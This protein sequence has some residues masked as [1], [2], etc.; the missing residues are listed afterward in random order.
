MTFTSRGAGFISTGG[1][2]RPASAE[3]GFEIVR[4]R[5]FEPLTDPAQFKDRDVI[6]RSFADAG[7][8][9]V[10]IMHDLNLSAMFSDRL[11]LLHQGRLLA[12]GPPGL[13]LTPDRLSQVYGVRVRVDRLPDGRTSCAPD[14][15]P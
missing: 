5:L 10:A 12:E 1:P 13:V 2:W 8:G 14:L 6:A 11:L 3:E 15:A 9:V 4:R 7:G